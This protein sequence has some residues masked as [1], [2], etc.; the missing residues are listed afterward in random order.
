MR[1]RSRW[2]RVLAFVL[3][4]MSWMGSGRAAPRSGAD[5]AELCKAAELKQQYERHYDEGKYSEGISLAEEAC[6]I[7]EEELGQRSLELAE[8]LNDLAVLYKEQGEYGK[9]E[10]LF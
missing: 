4:G 9:A 5:E 8:C 2:W 7:L 10:P 3:L 1:P 6:S